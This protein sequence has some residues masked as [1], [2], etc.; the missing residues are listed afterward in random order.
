M[1][2]IK[3]TSKRGQALL[4]KA[5]RNEGTELR[6]VYGRWS[7]EKEDVM[8]K[9]REAYKADDGENFRIISHCRDNF[10][11]AWEYTDKETGETMTRVETYCN[12]YIIDGSRVEE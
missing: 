5:S 2:I 9:C 3:G 12:T 10:S 1:A 11:V 6:Q 8:R 7:D 4:A